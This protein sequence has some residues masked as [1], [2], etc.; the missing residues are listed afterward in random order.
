VFVLQ[1]PLRRSTLT[2]LRFP[3]TLIKAAVSLVITIP[4]LPSL[5]E[6]YKTLRVEWIR[7]R[8]ETARLREELRH[9]RE[10]QA[11]LQTASSQEIVATI[12]SRSTIPT[13]QT[14]LLDKG[15]LQGVAL[16]TAVIDADGVVGRVTELHT[17]TSLVTLLTDPDSRIAGLVERSRESGLLVGRGHGHC[18]FIYL[19]AH[20]DIEAQDR[21][22][23]AGFGGP[24]PK[25]LLLGTVTHV[26]R[27][28]AAGTARAVVR[29]A[30]HLG[31]LEEVLCVLP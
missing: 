29:P 16:E 26:V 18:E 8:A 19:E 4:R 3:F 10:S 25:G 20:A 15:M 23:T 14:V 30:A 1:E 12:L 5:A 13:E 27:D 2:V 7:Q 22:L 17:T 24:L 6:N 21:I 31:R 28:E 9:F 11:L